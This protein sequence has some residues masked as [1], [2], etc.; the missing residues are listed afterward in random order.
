MAL[1]AQLP[2]NEAER[3]LSVRALIS[4]DGPSTPELEA[5]VKLA[6][7]VFTTP[8]AA[9][10]IVD[11]DWHR[12]ACQVGIRTSECPRD[13]SIC[14]RV[15][16]D[17][18]VVVVPDLARHPELR[19]LPYVLGEPGFRSYAGAP[20]AL[21][22]GLPVGAFCLLD[23]EPREFSDRE[24]ANLMHF[25]EVASGL[26]RLQ[27]ANHVMGFA[28]EKLR[29]AAITDPMTGF[30]NRAALVSIV[31]GMLA[32]AFSAHQTVGVLYMDMDGFKTINDTLGHPAGDDVLKQAAQRIT[33]CLGV[34]EIAVRM[35]GDEFAVFVPNLANADALA[36]LSERLVKRF[37]SPFAVGRHIVNAR[38]SVG[39]ALAPHAGSDRLSLLQ[40]VDEALYEAKASGRDRF[41]LR[42]S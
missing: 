29:L 4:A 36:G 23:T 10:N 7:D 37:R 14:S 24:I 27:K 34:Q 8:Y 6:K 35:G 19:D 9:V 11:A 20:V 42:S 28:E 33:E 16:F 25:A 31:D 2:D 41:V 26:L 22:P 32:D 38:L 15:V 1:P 40:A 30:Y 13:I 18:E 39:A 3:L 21:E 12:V 17:N 5:L